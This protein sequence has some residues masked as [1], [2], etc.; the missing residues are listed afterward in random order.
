MTH[1]NASAAATLRRVSR[2][3]F[4]LLELVIVIVIISLLI[5]TGLA[6]GGRVV[7][8]GKERSTRQVLASLDQAMLAYS[9]T[10]GTKFPRAHVD[11][12]GNEFPLADAVIV[13]T[14]NPVPSG[15]YAVATLMAE[16]SSR[17]IMEG[18]PSDF[19]QRLPAT[20]TAG[21]FVS[22]Q[23]P[24]V[25]QGAT[26]NFVNAALLEVRDAWGT[27]MRFVHP[28]YHGQ[29]SNRQMQFLQ[30]G[31]AVT[32]QLTRNETNSD[33][34]LCPQN[35]PYFYSA[36]PDKRFDTREDNLYSVEPKFN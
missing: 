15:L 19:V 24:Q 26:N 27:P 18:M 1:I 33:S 29:Y 11:E 17:V 8:S 13:A 32:V 21:V 4:S 34:G 16:P 35:K 22:G 36:G 6:V 28:E 3:G 30:N 14:G 10:K 23:P 25:R 5:A 31:A 7:G 20:S 12:Q 2:P 9:G